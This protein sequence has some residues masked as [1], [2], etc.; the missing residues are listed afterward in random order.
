MRGE[1]ET[2]GQIRALVNAAKRKAGIPDDIPEL[3]IAAFRR[4]Q[5]AGQLGLFDDVA[6]TLRSAR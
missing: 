2:A 5:S 3:S 6:C 4:P 1:G